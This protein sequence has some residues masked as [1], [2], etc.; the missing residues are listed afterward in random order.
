VESSLIVVAIPIFFASIGVEM[1]VAHRTK[2]RVYRFQ[3]SINSLSCGVSEQVVDLGMKVLTFGSYVLLYENVRL[4]DLDASA[5]WVWILGAILV[6][7]AYYFW[8][9]ASHRVGFLWAAHVVH[10]QSEEY[11]LS[12]ALRQSIT[13]S[14]TGAPFYWPLAILGFPPA[15]FITLSTLNTL[16]QFWIHTRLVKRLGPLE[17]VLNT[18]SHHRVHHGIDPKYIDK[19]YAGIFIVW[20]RV[21]G[22]F[23]REEEEPAYGTVKPLHSWSPLW[24]NAEGW[25]RMVALA[26]EC[27][28]WRD[29][30]Y[31]FIAP[32]EWRPDELGGD[33]TIPEVD[34][35]SRVKYAQPTRPGLD[36]YVA[37]Q[38]A[39]V[40][41]AILQLLTT[42]ETAPWPPTFVVG[43]WVMASLVSWGGLFE[44]KRWAP[45]LEC[46][47]QL[48]SPA[49]CAWIAPAMVLSPW[50]PLVWSAISLA[51]AGWFV[52]LWRRWSSSLVPATATST[53][54]GR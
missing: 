31:A 42:Y 32:P 53:I 51:C 7:L 35:E 24:A 29:K 52:M 8:H 33:V 36:V 18:P 28:R 6:D 20:D 1:W 15:M 26:R 12:T 14:T 3:D 19:N 46:A 49:I 38:F 13:T 21:F 9:R 40:A 17:V 45:P 11:N 54:T 5:V 27:T 23:A 10:H 41:L 30:L 48:A 2:Q 25:W 4:F 37:V 39:L 34:H 22:T 44:H 43:A 16:Y 47:R 50:S